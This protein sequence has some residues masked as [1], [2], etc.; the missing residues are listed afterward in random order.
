MIYSFLNLVCGVLQNVRIIWRTTRVSERNLLLRSESFQKAFPFSL[1]FHGERSKSGMTVVICMFVAVASA[2]LAIFSF[3]CKLPITS[4]HPHS[5]PLF[6]KRQ[7][8]NKQNKKNTKACHCSNCYNFSKT[9]KQKLFFILWF[10]FSYVSFVCV[11]SEMIRSKKD[12]V[13]TH[14]DSSGYFS[15]GWA[16]IHLNV[17]LYE[18]DL[19]CGNRYKA[20]KNNTRSS[21]L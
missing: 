3:M 5:L 20:Y 16:F 8:E 18:M 12:F 9:T 17:F 19:Y 21:L 15:P 10:F 6:E 13:Q 4:A 11:F 7:R 1:P 14:T 2:S